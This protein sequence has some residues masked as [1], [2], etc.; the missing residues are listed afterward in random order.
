MTKKEF[1]GKLGN[2]YD[3]ATGITPHYHEVQKSL[4][5][6]VKK[7][8]LNSKKKIIK[9]LEIGC[10]TGL[11]TELILNIDP[12]INVVGIDISFL[13]LEQAKSRLKSFLGSRLSL[14]L[15]DVN[16][17]MENSTEKHDIIASA[18]TIHN[19]QNQDKKKLFSIIRKSLNPNGL[20][21]NADI[22]SQNDE[23]EH[24][25]ELDFMLNRASYF[26]EIKKPELKQEWIDHYKLDD[27]PKRKIT[28]SEYITLLKNSGF[29][30][31]NKT[32]R[33][34]MEATFIANK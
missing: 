1:Q 27:T 9:V 15:E 2:N 20:F 16:E 29:K 28:E 6:E 8:C 10:G 32:Y 4:V 34:H 22:I 17:F 23:L 26:D 12:R 13:M 19:L 30:N 7:F 33:K 18:Y 21:I 3:L 14:F 11:T 31:I 5:S 24:Q 25:K